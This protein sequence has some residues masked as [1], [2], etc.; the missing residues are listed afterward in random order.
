MANQIPMMIIINTMKKATAPQGWNFSFG[1]ISSDI[2]M[3]LRSKL[4]ANSNGSGDFC[5][6]CSSAG[7]LRVG[8]A[9]FASM[10]RKERFEKVIAYFDKAMPDPETELE[11]QD[12]YELIVAVIL[13]AQCTDERVNMT[14]PAL[15]RKF[16]DFKSMAK[17]KFEQVQPMIKSV[18]YP[19]QKSRHLIAMAKA[20]INDF[21]GELPGEVESLQTLQGVGRKTANVVAS[22]LF[23][24]PA[25]AVDTHVFRVARR[26]G[27][28]IN[29]KTPRQTEDQLVKH[30]P[31]KHIPKAHHWLILHGRYV[32]LARK[33]KC[34]ECGITA[35][36]KYY[37]QVVSK[38]K[39]SN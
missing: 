17:A 15:F 36:C 12:P 29:A 28:T 5:H 4:T 10:T 19:N 31:E 1:W 26:I 9:I 11:Y 23:K 32:C 8:A 39:K 30:I 38:Q 37:K 16:P 33:P 18:T 27:L 6:R 21:D 22:V 20:V 2:R 34:D 13:S 3:N 35:M 7:T 25:M 24:A 14:T